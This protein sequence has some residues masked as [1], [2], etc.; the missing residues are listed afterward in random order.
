[1]YLRKNF[2]IWRDAEKLLIEVE[3]A[4]RNFPR[5]HKYSLGTELRQLAGKIIAGITHAINNKE[6][7]QKMLSQ[8]SFYIEEL[9]IKIQLAKT[10]Q[11]FASFSQFETIAKLAVSLG[12]QTKGWEKKITTRR[13]G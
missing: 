7:R 5:Y 13:G 8:L 1:M 9:K 10:L 12:R 6:I 2:P 4:V 11:A 3:L